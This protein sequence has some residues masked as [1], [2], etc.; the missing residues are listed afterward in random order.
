MV[1]DTS[2]MLAILFDEPERR[3]FIAAIDR[4]ATR[5]MSVASFVECSIVLDAR[6]GAD[7]IR[8]LDLFVARAAVDLVPVDVDQAYIARQAH[9]TFGRGRHV[10]GLNYGDCFA[11]SLARMRAEPLLFKGGDFALTDVDQV[12]PAT[13]P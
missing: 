4:D 6:H 5:L 7:A 1:I 11:Y 2:A 3:A 12:L 8:D 10:A 13:A 9:R